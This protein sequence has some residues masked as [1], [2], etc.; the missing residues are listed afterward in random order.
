M[1]HEHLLPR[2]IENVH[3][4]PATSLRNGTA[5]PAAASTLS[6][7]VSGKRPPVRDRCQQ[8]EERT[9]ADGGAEALGRQRCPTLRDS[10]LGAAE[11]YAVRNT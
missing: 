9:P 3:Q 4:C 2:A 10:P 8:R 5:W 1:I 6:T 11:S 7:E